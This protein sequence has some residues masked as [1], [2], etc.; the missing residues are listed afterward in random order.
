[1]SCGEPRFLSA[2]GLASLISGGYGGRWTQQVTPGFYKNIVSELWRSW[3][4]GQHLA[5]LTVLSLYTLIKQTRLLNNFSVHSNC[6]LFD[7]LGTSIHF[8][9]ILS[10]AQNVINK[11]GDTVTMH[12]AIRN[13]PLQHKV[14][15]VVW[16]VLIFRSALVTCRR[17]KP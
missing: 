3:H 7:V 17:A 16:S 10:Y 4:P 8:P 14:Y 5:C 15:Y 6:I 11:R 12:G 13:I 9:E 2:R 1:M